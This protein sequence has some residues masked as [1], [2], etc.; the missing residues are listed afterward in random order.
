MNYIT[1]EEAINALE[2][3]ER[4]RFHFNSRSIEVTKSTTLSELRFALL[5]N[6]TLTVR[7]VENGQYSIIKQHDLKTWS[8]YYQAVVEGD[9]TFE[10]RVND[11]NYN[12]G[13]ILILKEYDPVKQIFTGRE[14]EKVVTYLTDFAQQNGY[15]VMSIE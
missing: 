9:K 13:D 2:R 1:R 3:G 10:I 12:V 6:L 15:V 11:R 4:V 5:A 8:E 14:I 7:D